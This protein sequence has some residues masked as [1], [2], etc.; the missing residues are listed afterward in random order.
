VK[1]AYGKMFLRGAQVFSQ[2]WDIIKTIE[3]KYG[4]DVMGIA[5]EI[6]W[7]NA[8]EAGQKAAKQYDKQGLKELYL[9]YSAF[10]EAICDMRCLCSMMIALKSTVGDVPMLRRSRSWVALKRR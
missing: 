8:Y 5:R 10:F 1:E 7:K 3:K 4:I 2:M 6:R 9:A